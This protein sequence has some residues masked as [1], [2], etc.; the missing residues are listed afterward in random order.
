MRDQCYGGW[1]EVVGSSKP[2]AMRAVRDLSG[3]G[4]RK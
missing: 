3:I 1:W 2:R 4:E